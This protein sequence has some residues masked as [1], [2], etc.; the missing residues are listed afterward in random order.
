MLLSLLLDRHGDTKETR[1][2]CRWSQSRF[3]RLC[4]IQVRRDPIDV[5]HSRRIFEISLRQDS[6]RSI[7]L[8]VLEW[9]S[10][11][12][13]DLKFQLRLSSWFWHEFLCRTWK[14]FLDCISMSRTRAIRCSFFNSV[15][16]PSENISK[17]LDEVST[18]IHCRF[19]DWCNRKI[20]PDPKCFLFEVDLHENGKKSEV[21]G[22]KDHAER[23]VTVFRSSIDLR[24]RMSLAL[25]GEIPQS[26]FIRS[27]FSPYSCFE[28][29][30]VR[31]F[32]ERFPTDFPR[33]SVPPISSDGRRDVET[34]SLPPDMDDCSR[35][36][37]FW[38]R[39]FRGGER[40]DLSSERKNSDGS[41]DLAP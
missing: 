41:F 10:I 24:T 34:V 4:Q 27:T 36:E 13:I 2:S 40:D 19:L 22:A 35:S 29:S 6:L 15:A 21:F 18:V 25:V 28:Y 7:C 30:Q 9:I 1:H 39:E 38:Y 23:K 26:S 33:D 5:D 31:V 3:V 12:T 37:Q 11:E 20:E 8:Y 32:D 16:K 14:I 17:R